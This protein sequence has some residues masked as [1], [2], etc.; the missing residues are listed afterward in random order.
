M[1]FLQE[2]L[3]SLIKEIDQYGAAF[4]P[5]LKI[6]QSEYKSI[7][8]G[9]ITLII[10][11]L[12]FTYFVYGIAQWQEGQV[13]P[14]IVFYDQVLDNIEYNVGQNQLIQYTP[15]IFTS[16]LDPFNKSAIVIMALKLKEISTLNSPLTTERIQDINGTLSL[17]NLD[18][19]SNITVQQ[20][21]F[22][23]FTHCIESYLNEGESCAS[24]ETVKK[25]WQQTNVMVIKMFLQQYSTVSRKLVTLEKNFYVTYQQ[26]SSYFNQMNVKTTDTQA[27]EG[28][29]FPNVFEYVFISDIQ[30]ISQG[31]NIELYSQ[32]F[33]TP[34]YMVFAIQMDMLQTSQNIQFP[35]I[36]QILAN[37]GS[38]VSLIFIF[39]YFIIYLNENGLY[40]QALDEIIHMLVPL[41]LKVTK[42][43]YGKIL[44]VSNPKTNQL[45]DIEEYKIYYEKLSNIAQQK[46][47]YANLI[48]EMSRLQYAIQK[49]IPKEELLKLRDAE[50]KIS[51]TALDTLLPQNKSMNQ[52][53]PEKEL[54]PIQRQAGKSS[55]E[56]RI[57]YKDVLIEK[58]LNQNNS[59]D[60]NKNIQSQQSIELKPFVEPQNETLLNQENKH[61][62]TYDDFDISLFCIKL[63]NKE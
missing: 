38:I 57:E 24:N 45:Y 20:Y 49:L 53:V 32:L 8:G 12:S 34:S 42:T 17:N 5:S 11:G 33:Q 36:S 23:V 6:N 61:I 26:D 7:I 46:L 29:L 30:Q 60:K 9:I 43:W 62:F 31:L 40:H 37:I 63:Y 59:Q 15:R 22:V 18:L 55:S 48:Y 25:F 39:Q 4:R 54:M 58:E 27:D 13:L 28:I 52:I 50:V 3:P 41:K 10:Y 56:S 51:L 44:E 14:S 47:S 19:Q 35:N 21:Y 1:K 16:G 2:H